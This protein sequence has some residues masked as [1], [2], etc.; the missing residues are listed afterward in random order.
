MTCEACKSGNH[1]ACEE[2][3]DCRKEDEQ[4]SKMVASGSDAMLAEMV[5]SNIRFSG[6]EV[7]ALLTKG[8]GKDAVVLFVQQVLRANKA[9][10]C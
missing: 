3:C 8:A 10:Q 2:P 4:I 1:E 6:S 9:A 5:Y 7:C